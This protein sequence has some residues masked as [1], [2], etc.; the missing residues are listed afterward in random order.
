LQK[1]TLLIT[2]DGKQQPASVRFLSSAKDN[3]R[4]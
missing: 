4:Q 3:V 2:V 1:I